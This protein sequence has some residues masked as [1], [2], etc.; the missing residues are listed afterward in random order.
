[1][2]AIGLLQGEMGGDI[3][4]FPEAFLLE[5]LSTFPVW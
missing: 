5:D 4:G 3:G 1:V 2:V